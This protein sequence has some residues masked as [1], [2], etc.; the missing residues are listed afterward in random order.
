MLLVKKFFKC[1]IPGKEISDASKNSEVLVALSV[2]SRNEVDKMIN[3]AVSAGGKEYRETT[4][5]DWMYSRA[6]QDFDGHIWEI[7]YM[8]EAKMPKEMKNKG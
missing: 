2:E 5:F 1:F 8:D 6:F 7:L 3:N 4:D